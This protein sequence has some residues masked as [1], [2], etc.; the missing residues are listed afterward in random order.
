MEVII[1]KD[2]Q[3]AGTVA[4]NIIAERIK[5]NPKIVLGLATGSTPI[6]TYQTLVKKCQEDNLDFSRITTFNLDEYKGLL[7][8]HE[9]SYRYFM[10]QNLFDHININ[11][12]QT[13]IPSGIDLQDPEQYDNSIESAGGIDLQLLGLGVNGHVGFNE[14]GTSFDSKTAVVDLAQ[15]TISS[16][17]RFFSTKEEVP[18]QAVSMGLA[19]IM[20]AKEILL[21]ATGS[22]K[23]EAVYHLV[24]GKVTEQWPCSILQKHSNTTIIIDKKAASLLEK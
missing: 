4:A 6:T 19:S 12:A 7:P 21:I 15:S 9:Q 2:N 14:P 5:Q 16:N 17:S 3:E 23:A 20:N 24:K 22:N 13:F 10:N 1:V 18:T 11:K 8:T